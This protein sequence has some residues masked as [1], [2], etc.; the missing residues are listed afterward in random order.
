MPL[1]SPPLPSLRVTFLTHTTT[2]IFLQ[3]KTK[4]KKSLLFYASRLLQQT[5]L[6]GADCNVTDEQ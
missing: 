4:K 1:S 2:T 6:L 5:A 3:R